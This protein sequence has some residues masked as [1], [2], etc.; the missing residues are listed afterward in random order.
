MGSG[1]S[2]ERRKSNQKKNR[3]ILQLR[4]KVSPVVGQIFLIFVKESER[5]PA[6]SVPRPK[7]LKNS[8]IPKRIKLNL[9]ITHADN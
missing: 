6:K 1:R 4:P 7:F 2:L 5:G 8:A 3:A 9:A